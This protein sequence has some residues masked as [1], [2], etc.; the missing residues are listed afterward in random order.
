MNILLIDNHD[1]FT[2]NLVD[3]IQYKLGY[4]VT[5]I[6]SE[7]VDIDAVASYSHIIFSPGP[8]IPSEQPA[9]FKILERYAATKKI[10][11][12]CL[13]MQAIGMYYGGDLY[14]LPT[15]IHGQQHQISISN[16]DHIFKQLNDT[17]PVGLYHS[18]AIATPLSAPLQIMAMSERGILMSIAHE[19]YAVY[20]VQFHPESHL[21]PDGK[22]IIQNF[23]AL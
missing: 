11:G 22:Q 17:I 10:L 20:G 4:D 5:I 13:G 16:H 6:K 3:L 21:T 12:I 8:G 18:W 15:V 9:M 23:L 2:Y 14:N 19:S 1:S 7:A